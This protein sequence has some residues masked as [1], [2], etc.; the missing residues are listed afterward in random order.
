MPKSY[1]RKKS[2]VWFADRLPREHKNRLDHWQQRLEN[3]GGSWRI[4]NDIE[5][6]DR[7]FVMN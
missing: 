1:S 6:L 4:V 2:R 3:G 5:R 7:L